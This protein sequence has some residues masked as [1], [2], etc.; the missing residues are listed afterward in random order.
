MENKSFEGKMDDKSFTSFLNKINSAPPEFVS[1]GDG[2]IITEDKN[3]PFQLFGLFQNGESDP[4]K[5]NDKGNNSPELEKKD[6]PLDSSL[7]KDGSK[8]K[9]FKKESLTKETQ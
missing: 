2:L 8:P 4:N 9:G 1:G 7:K 3:D 6:S 5:L